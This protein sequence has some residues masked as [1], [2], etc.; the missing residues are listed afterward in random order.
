VNRTTRKKV[1]KQMI[2]NSRPKELEIV[3]DTQRGLALR[4]FWLWLFHRIV[5]G[6]S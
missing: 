2:A 4:L 5:G 3:P 1:R 6:D